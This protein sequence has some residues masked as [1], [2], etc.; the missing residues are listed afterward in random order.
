MDSSGIFVQ[1]S[2]IQKLPSIPP[3]PERERRFRPINFPM[4]DTS[5][6][7]SRVDTGITITCL[8]PSLLIFFFKGLKR[9]SSIEGRSTEQFQVNDRIALSKNRHGTI[10]YVGPTP[11]GSGN[12]LKSSWIEID[13]HHFRR[14]VRYRIRFCRWFT[15]WMFECGWATIL[16]MSTTTWRVCSKSKFEKVGVEYFAI[17]WKDMRGNLD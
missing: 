1:P 4:L 8:N 11:L 2:S 5:I 9:D 17:E 14:L 10:K 3:S 12:I 13:L 15:R 6:V 16:S 7:S